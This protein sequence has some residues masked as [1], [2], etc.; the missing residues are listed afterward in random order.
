[1]SQPDPAA[2]GRVS[3]LVVRQEGQTHTRYKA[4]NQEELCSTKEPRR[5]STWSTPSTGSSATSCQAEHLAEGHQAVRYGLSNIDRYLYI[6]PTVAGHVG[7]KNLV[8]Y[9]SNYIVHLYPTTQEYA[10][11]LIVVTAYSDSVRH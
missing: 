6:V 4:N 7:R 2:K 3:K 5:Q 1:M 11:V 10:P 8:L 9:A